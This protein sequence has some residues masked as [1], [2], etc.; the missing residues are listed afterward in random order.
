MAETAGKLR[1]G[2]DLDLLPGDAEGQAAGM[3]TPHRVDQLLPAFFV[4]S[5]LL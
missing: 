1:E 2:A 4:A 3:N 5:S